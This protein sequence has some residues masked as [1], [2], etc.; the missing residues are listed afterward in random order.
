MR[1]LDAIQHWAEVAPKRPAH[2]SGSR[3]LSYGELAR[4]SDKLAAYL[5]Q[6]FGFSD[7]SDE[8]NAHRPIAIYGHKEPEMLIG[9]LAAVK[10]GHP[11]IPIDVAIPEHRIEFMMSASRALVLLTVADIA[12]LTEGT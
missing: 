9:F 12:R 8:A 2:L 5:I 6:K 1:I 4:R 3:V 10:S 11:Y 7:P